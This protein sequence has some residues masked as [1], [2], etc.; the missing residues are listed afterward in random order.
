MKRNTDDAKE[1]HARTNAKHHE[2]VALRAQWLN[3]NPDKGKED[4][5]YKT[6]LKEM[7]NK[8]S[9]EFVPEKSNT[10]TKFLKPKQT[11]TRNQ[12]LLQQK[13]F[14]GQPS[15][16]IEFLISR[17]EDNQTSHRHVCDVKKNFIEN[18]EELAPEIN[19]T[20]IGK[21]FDIRPDVQNHVR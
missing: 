5:N 20:S 13:P 2:A 19:I 7:Q 15:A 6:N 17:S 16:E 8:Y 1:K 4:W 10:L 12:V 14:Q 21:L 18:L 11:N 9:V 3:D